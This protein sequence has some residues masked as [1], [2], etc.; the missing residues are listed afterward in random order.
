MFNKFCD[1]MFNLLHHPLKVLK[2][3]SKLYTLFIVFGR[4]FDDIRSSI[5]NVI[6]ESN[7]NTASGI[8]L[9]EIAKDRNM[10]R[11]SNEND[12]K[13]RQRIMLKVN[14]SKML[15]T[16]KGLIYAINSLSYNCQIEPCYMYDNKR[17]AEF[18]VII[19][20][21]IDNI[22]YSLNI[23]KDTIMEVKQA[24]SKPNFAMKYDIVN[25]TKNKFN[26]QLELMYK[27]NYWNNYL[28]SLFYDSTASYE[29]RY[30]YSGYKE[31]LDKLG[32]IK[33]QLIEMKINVKI[34][35]LQK[36]RF[37]S[38][39]EYRY[40]S[41]YFYDSSIKYNSGIRREEI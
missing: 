6:K 13:F 14:I 26:V 2:E 21:D 39:T 30:I 1:Y 23:I 29:G 11:Y 8:Y 17:W 18:Y 5:S 24:S 41:K 3:K 16:K 27:I 40:N 9:E 7:L 22:N 38:K 31:K 37:E 20:E 28:T 15:G 35:N 10:L 33:L 32:T 25:V 12:E 19:I 4:C 36:F 34:A